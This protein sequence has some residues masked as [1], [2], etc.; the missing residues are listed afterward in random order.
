MKKLIS[1]F[2]FGFFVLGV[3]PLLAEEYSEAPNVMPEGN[4]GSA[5][6]LVD[7]KN[8]RLLIDQE[9]IVVTI[10]PGKGKPLPISELGGS[11]EGPEEGQ[12]VGSAK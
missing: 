6:D 12:N 9:S 8:E 1:L 4:P 10:Q 5:K 11:K 2:L 3:S 7:F